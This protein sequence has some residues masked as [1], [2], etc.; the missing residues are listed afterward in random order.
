MP[1]IEVK[2]PQAEYD[3]IAEIAKKLGLVVETLIQQETDRSVE[4]ISAWL[5]RAEL[6]IQ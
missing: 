6:L 1:K 2:I 3:V 5:Q 4:T